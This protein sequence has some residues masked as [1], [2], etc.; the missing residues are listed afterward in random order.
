MPMAMGKYAVDYEERINY[1]RLRKERLDRAKN[2][3]KTKG[4]VL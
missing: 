4:W 1:D 2:R 3:L